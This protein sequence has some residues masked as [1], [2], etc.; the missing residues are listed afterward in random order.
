MYRPIALPLTLWKG[1]TQQWH[2]HGHWH[3]NGNAKLNAL[4]SSEEDI[5]RPALAGT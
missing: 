3:N 2:F 1:V 4:W 5:L